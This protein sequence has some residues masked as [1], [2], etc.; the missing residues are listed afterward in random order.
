[1]QKLINM[2][3]PIEDSSPS[4]FARRLSISGQSEGLLSYKATVNYIRT[5]KY[6]FARWDIDTYL[7]SLLKVIM[8]MC[9]PSLIPAS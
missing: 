3:G 8:L 9:L 6:S 7:L 5:C 2:F 1:M 4:A